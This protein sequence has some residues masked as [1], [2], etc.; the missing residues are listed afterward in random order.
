MPSP[1]TAWLDAVSTSV[2]MPVLRMLTSSRTL[3]Q[4]RK[5]SVVEGLLL[6]TVSRTFKGSLWVT[7]WSV[8]CR[9]VVDAAEDVAAIIRCT[10][11]ACWK[12]QSVATSAII[13]VDATTVF[14]PIS[15]RST[16]RLVR[17]CPVLVISPALVRERR[18]TNPTQCLCFWCHQDRPTRLAL[19]YSVVVT[20]KT[21]AFCD[22]RSLRFL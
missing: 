6:R 9:S 2:R 20:H 12:R 8:T 21:I 14:Q 17:C 19:V 15:C 4:L 16:G 18:V 13:P 5:L 10:W 22:W 7:S 3:S 11:W 1:S